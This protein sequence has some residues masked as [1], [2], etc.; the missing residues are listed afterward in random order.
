MPLDG[1]RVEE[2]GVV[3]ERAGD[4]PSACSLQRR[5]SGRTW[6]CRCPTG[7][8]SQRER[9]AAQRPGAARSAGRTSPGRAACG[10]GRARAAAPPPAARRAGPGA[11]RRRASCSRTWAS[12]SR[13]VGLPA[14]RRRAAT[15]VLTKKPIR[16]SSLRAACGRRS[17]CRRRR[18]PGRCSGD[19][20]TWKPASSIMKSVAPSRWRQR[21]ERRR[22]ARAGSA[23]GE[24]RA[25]V[26]LHGRARPVGRQLQ[27][28][29]RAGELLA[30]SSR[31]ARP[32]PR[33]GASSRCQAAKSAYWTG[34]GGSGGRWP[35]C[36]GRVER[37]E[38][39]DE[40]AHRPAV[41]D[42]VVH[43]QQQHVLVVAQPQQRARA[44]AGPR[45]RSKG[46]GASSARARRASASR[47]GSGSARQVHAAAASSARA[48]G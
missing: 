11:R 27:R 47:C 44:A 28:G 2:V 5:A 1:R 10:S 15:S 38:L 3:L 26:G 19:S 7:S 25:A 41:G 31:A 12:S 45:A 17:A 35:A 43:R 33:P 40:H 34:S 39:A 20:S 23:H 8:G 48:R 22:T 42:D 29:G 14:Q 46:R 24:R 36:E 18:R 13:K 30:S 21:L 32:A 6:R 4:S 16:P 37:A 9:P